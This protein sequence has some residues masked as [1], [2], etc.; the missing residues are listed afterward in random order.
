LLDGND[1]EAGE[2]EGHGGFT[3]GGWLY[4]VVLRDEPRPNN[5]L[6]TVDNLKTVIARLDR[7]IQ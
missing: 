3:Q 2:G 4:V 5:D 7:A 6:K 1:E